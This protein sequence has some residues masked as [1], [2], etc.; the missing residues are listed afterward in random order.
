[1]ESGEDIPL[2][3]MQ[4]QEGEGNEEENDERDQQEITK[5][6]EGPG[7]AIGGNYH[8]H[9][10]QPPA[11]NIQGFQQRKQHSLRATTSYRC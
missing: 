3:D 2:H 8:Q 11:T 1:M 9:T 10:L 6:K 4:Q 7:A 5:Q